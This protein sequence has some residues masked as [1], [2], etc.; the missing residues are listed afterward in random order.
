[1]LI[2]LIYFIMSI[3]T[4]FPGQGSQSLNMCREFFDNFNTAKHLFQEAEEA[5]KFKISDVIF[6]ENDKLLMQTENSQPAIALCSVVILNTLE[7]E[8]GFDIK[9]HTT[10]TAGH[11]LGEYVALYFANVL[12]FESCI[13]LLRQRGQEMSKNTSN[14]SGSMA[15]IIGASQ[16]DINAMI[17]SCKKEGEILSVANYNSKDQIVVSGNEKSI[18][19]CVARHKE[20]KAKRAIK[21]AVSNAFHSPLMKNASDNFQEI[22]NNYTFHTPDLSV[23]SNV[24]AEIYTPECD[25]KAALVKQIYSQVKWYNSMQKSLHDERV[26]EFVEIGNGAVLSGL[27]KKISLSEGRSI[28]IH[29]LNSINAVENFC[30]KNR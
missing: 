4:C 1:M 30:S 2:S 16:E 24:N 18:D 25:I 9:K 3:L 27:M 11:S 22:I 20:F 5:M 26:T 21:L 13:A 7:K 15:A 23:I 19:E 28:E 12:S 8:F 14:L 6:G 17:E 10:H 29:T